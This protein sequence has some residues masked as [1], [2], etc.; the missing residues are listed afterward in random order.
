MFK[1]VDL[2]ETIKKVGKERL[3]QLFIDAIKK[4]NDI[5]YLEKASD[6]SKYITVE[7]GV[8]SGKKLRFDVSYDH[9]KECIDERTISD[10]PSVWGEDLTLLMSDIDKKLLKREKSFKEE[11]YNAYQLH[12]MLSHGYSLHDAA[13]AVFDNMEEDFRE[14]V[15]YRDDPTTVI[16]TSQEEGR[17]RFLFETGFGSGTIFACEEEFLDHEFLDPEYMDLLFSL[18]GSRKGYKARW[19]E[20]ISEHVSN[21]KP[22]PEPVKKFV[23]SMAVNGRIDVEIECPEQEK[24]ERIRDLA[25]QKFCDADLSMMEVIGVEPVN[26][27]DEDG[28]LLFD[29]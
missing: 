18:M 13:E 11:C 3:V 2:S 17:D 23:V 28:E 8:V 16:T 1:T 9:C 6:R 22:S 4:E 24:P 15:K 14:R 10:D 12:W 19:R 21:S 7:K 20:C 27:S 5:I 26:L 25:K 29:F